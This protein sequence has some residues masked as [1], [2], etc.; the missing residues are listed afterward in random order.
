MKLKDTFWIGFI[1]GIAGPG[2]ALFFF[3][4]LKFAQTPLQE[5]IE[6]AVDKGMLSPLLS[7][8][9]VVN[10]GLF[11][12][13]LQTNRYFAAR[14]VILSTLIFGFVIVYLKFIR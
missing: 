8:C 11:F 6:T 13:L 9:T 12:L 2:V 10:L 5:F 3:Y 14:G 4:K 7:L 1:L